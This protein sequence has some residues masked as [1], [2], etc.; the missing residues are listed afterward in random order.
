MPEVFLKILNMSAAASV[1]IAVVLLARLAL[2]RAPKKW[3]YLLWS[4]VGFRLCCPVS[5]KAAFSV[6]RLAPLRPVETTTSVVAAGQT[7]SIIY[8]PMFTSSAAAAFSPAGTDPALMAPLPSGVITQQAMGTPVI[9]AAQSTPTLAAIFAGMWLMG[10]A[11]LVIYSLCSYV[12][13]RRLVDD[14]VLVEGNV[15]ETDRIRSPFILG[16]FRPRIYLPTGLTGERRSYVLAHERFHLRRGDHLIRFFAFLLLVVHWFN[17]LVWLAFRL[18]SRDMEMSCDEKVLGTYEGRTK[19]YSSTLLSFAVPH[20][21]P[22]ASPLCFGESSVKSRIKNALAWHK[23]RTW[24]TLAAAILC[25]V[26]VAACAFNPAGKK[27]SFTDVPDEVTQFAV[28]YYEAAREGPEKAAEYVYFLSDEHRQRYLSGQPLEDYEIQMIK[29]LSD[30]LYFVSVNVPVGEDLAHN[31]INFIGRAEEGW[32][33][34]LNANAIP[35]QLRQAVDLTTAVPG[36]DPNNLGAEPYMTVWNP[37][38]VAVNVTPLTDQEGVRI[39]GRAGENLDLT[40][41]VP[42]SWAGR[43]TY[44]IHDSGLTVYC[45]ATWEEA[46]QMGRM[47]SLY[48]QSGWCP[49]DC[50]PIGNER[51]LAS[52]GVYTAILGR[53]SDVQWTAATQEEYASLYADMDQVRF[54]MSPAMEKGTLNET[55]W[56]PGTVTLY[57]QFA[58]GRRSLPCICDAETSKAVAA[59]LG[60]KDYQNVDGTDA[61]AQDNIWALWNGQYYIVNTHS[62]RIYA[63]GQHALAA[64]LTDEELTVIQTALH[65]GTVSYRILIDVEPLADRNALHIT[66]KNVANLDM[67]VILPESWAGR[68]GYAAYDGGV[69]IF[70]RATRDEVGE[71]GRLLWLD[72]SASQ[73]PLD[74]S[75]A[76]PLWV[77]ATNGDYTVTLGHPSDAQA[78]VATQKEY[79]ALYAEVDRVRFELSPAM[80]ENTFNWE[81]TAVLYWKS[82]NADGT[83]ALLGPVYCNDEGADVLRNMFTAREYVEDEALWVSAWDNVQYFPGGIRVIID[84]VSY[85]VYPGDGTVLSS[86]GRA[87]EPLTKSEVSQLYTALQG[88]TRE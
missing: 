78:T 64:P 66:G 88:E 18:M 3:S 87:A 9:P 14:A 22:A 45:R 76:A 40:V 67:T 23:P 29:R 68:Y 11:A 21:F 55:N 43:Y 5:L 74:T 80:R 37:Q 71:A 20:R 79:D 73:Q 24:V 61:L 34:F 49:M 8:I 54:E 31:F 59:L 86:M 1:V 47:F 85:Y 32:R 7:S 60:S 69:E 13:L 44:K 72:F 65:G 30:E 77:L 75:Y 6:F 62:M 26:A 27:L 81:R 15:Y 52:D 56:I 53:P 48:F 58:D 10:M 42:E 38:P 33:V 28:T 70:C 39:T 51:I 46:E 2:R 63:P 12:K 36:Y 25:L 50:P 4:A 83:E 16:L 84:S 19:E 35:T 41:T 57:K 17:P 82:G